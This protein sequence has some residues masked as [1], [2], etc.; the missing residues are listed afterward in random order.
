MRKFLPLKYKIHF[1]ATEK[2][3]S[4]T[5]TTPSKELTTPGS[6]QDDMYDDVTESPTTNEFAS[7]AFDENGI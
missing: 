4:A 6:K 3:E 2:S 7:D 5:T 1:S